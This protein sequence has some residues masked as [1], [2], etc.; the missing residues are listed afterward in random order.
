MVSLFRMCRLACGCGDGAGTS[1]IVYNNVPSP[2]HHTMKRF[3]LVILAAMLAQLGA[4]AQILSNGGFDRDWADW[5]T[6]VSLGATATFSIDNTIDNVNGH[7][8][9]KAAKV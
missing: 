1:L 7:T 3:L 5:T 6:T 2:K 9:S 8:G 4:S